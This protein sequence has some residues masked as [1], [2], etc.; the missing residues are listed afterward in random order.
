MSLK[1]LL[2]D[3]IKNWYPNA[4]PLNA[5]NEICDSAGHKRSNGERRLRELCD[6]EYPSVKTIK[7]GKG[8]ITG[9]KFIKYPVDPKIS[10]TLDE[11]LKNI[12]FVTKPTFGNAE[13][14][15]EIEKAMKSK[16]E[17]YKKSIIEKYK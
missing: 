2:F 1:S 15:K 12:L 5:I 3:A 17:F 13:R 4:V 7:G 11:Q 9:Y 10:M 8:Y 16:N 14:I 6:G